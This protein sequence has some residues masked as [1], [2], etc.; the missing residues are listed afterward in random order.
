MHQK[1]EIALGVAA[2]IASVHGP[3]VIRHSALRLFE[4][5]S[6]LTTPK[7]FLRGMFTSQVSAQQYGVT[8][9]Q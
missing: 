8:V 4:A 6:N 2:K 9:I 3:L 1:E 7:I 5:G